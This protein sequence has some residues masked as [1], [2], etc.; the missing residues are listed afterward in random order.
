MKASTNH[1]TSTSR[2]GDTYVLPT[3]DDRVVITVPKGTHV[4]FG[5]IKSAVPAAVAA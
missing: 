5:N 2:L 1:L 4:E 3:P